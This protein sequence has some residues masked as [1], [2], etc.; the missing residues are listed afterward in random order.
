VVIVARLN[1]LV[2]RGLLRMFG[3]R[4]GATGFVG[5]AR[6]ART[7]LTPTLPAFALVLALTLAAFAGMVRDAIT[8]G[9]IAASWQAAGADAL[10][11]NGG[12]GPTVTPQAQR[13][14]EAVPGVHTTAAAWI[15]VWTLPDNQQVNAVAVDL[16]SYAALV[17]TTQTW[18]RVPAAK[19]TLRPGQPVPVLASPSVAAQLAGGGTVTTQAGLQALHVRVAGVLS[20]TPAV[21]GSSSF[22]IVPLAAIHGYYG[23]PPL[24][25]LLVT[26]SGINDAAL[27]AVAHR[28]MFAS[29]VTT[30][31]AA[32]D[33]LADAPL[34]HGAYL[35]F[36][37][38]IA[39]AAALGLVVMVLGLALGASDRELTL[40]RL[41]T[42][43]L[44]HRQRV[45]LALLEVLPAL[46][47][48]AVAATGCAIALPGLL[49]PVLDL[50]VFTG[51]G[52][53]VRVLPDFNSFAL[54]LAGLAL[55]AAAAL[56]IET[57]AQQRRGAIAAQLRGGG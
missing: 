36:A 24:N 44:T 4:A 42:M 31:S 34:Q 28:T 3:R 21:P 53:P 55:L 11:D 33:A 56:G 40:A 51:S 12:T 19:L 7:S 37:L 23:A 29:V 17:A 57:R 32:L 26:G 52:T 35:L 22:F 2:L 27:T 48:A 15:T 43:G 13:A 8:R 39:A 25:V 5:L 16:A 38:A 20:G 47:A 54:P 18:P 50:S 9:E 10:I 14:I 45:R 6:A 49:A 41:A 30:R 1:P 46:L